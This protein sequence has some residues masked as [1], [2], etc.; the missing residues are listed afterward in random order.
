[1][2]AKRQGWSDTKFFEK[3]CTAR[4]AETRLLGPPGE[5]ERIKQTDVIIDSLLIPSN[6]YVM[7]RLLG[8]V[9]TEFRGPNKSRKLGRTHLTI[10]ISVRAIGPGFYEA[11][12]WRQERTM[13][14]ILH[15]AASFFPHQRKK[16]YDIVQNYAVPDPLA[17]VVRHN[18]LEIWLK[19]LR[20]W[21]H[22]SREEYR[23]ALHNIY[24]AQQLFLLPV[25]FPTIL[26]FLFHDDYHF[27]LHLQ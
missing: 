23:R 21:V 20:P 9:H 14:D 15:L 17:D 19:W 12:Y 5:G 13:D 24:L 10:T 6:R 7:T 1:M 27:H 11:N 25:L 22:K 2:S 18:L 3:G 16:N 26:S 4:F 8:H